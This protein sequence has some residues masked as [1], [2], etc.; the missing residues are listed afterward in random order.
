MSAWSGWATN[1]VVE[2]LEPQCVVEARDGSDMLGILTRR[3]EA[4]GGLRSSSVSTIIVDLE[5]LGDDSGRGGVDPECVV[6]AGDDGDMLGCWLQAELVTVVA[7]ASR[8][9]EKRGGVWRLVF[10]VCERP[11]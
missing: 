7:Q 1:P 4:C 8:P 3:E 5:R 9:Y 10:V 2:V 11:R 6:E